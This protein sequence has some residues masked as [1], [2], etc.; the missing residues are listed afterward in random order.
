MINTM[1]EKLGYCATCAK[2]TIE[3]FCTQEDEN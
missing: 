3:Y 1:L 2:K